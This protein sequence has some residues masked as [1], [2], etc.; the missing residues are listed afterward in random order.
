MGYAVEMYFDK[1][2]S[3]KIEDMWK[4]LIRE[5]NISDLYDFN[6]RPHISLGV[7]NDDIDIEAF[8]NK[9]EKFSEKNKCFKAKF[10]NI[11]IFN[12]AE[13][14]LFLAPKV[15]RQLLSFHEEFHRLTDDF[16]GQINKYY[17]PELWIPHCTMVMN[18]SRTKFLKCLEIVE[19]TFEPMQVQIEQIGIIKFRPVEHIESFN[20]KD[21]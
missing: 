11:G 5:A 2:S 19:D 9:V 1:K 12:T 8:I 17:L 6:S 15:D 10:S 7:Y 14:V 20:L 18:N 3:K 13:G 21:D 16:K 4:I